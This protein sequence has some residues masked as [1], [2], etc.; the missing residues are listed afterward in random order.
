[1]SVTRV[2][3]REW[4]ILV[5]ESRSVSYQVISPYDMHCHQGSGETVELCIEM[6]QRWIDSC[7]EE[8]YPEHPLGRYRPPTTYWPKK[9]QRGLSF[10]PGRHSTEEWVREVASINVPVRISEIER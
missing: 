7:I 4:S 6:G 5:V 2:Q 3:Y 8:Q 9:G 1:M 10:Y